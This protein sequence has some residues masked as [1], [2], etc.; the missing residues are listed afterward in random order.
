M[1]FETHTIADVSTQHIT[2]EDGDRIAVNKAPCQIAA[3]DHGGLFYIPGGDLT[4]KDIRLA[5]DE[6]SDA[7]VSLMVELWKQEIV[8]V[9]FDADAS[10]VE[11]A[12]VFDW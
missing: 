2:L 11:G 12:P 5:F 8:Y 10:E 1:K 9:R 6:M 7:F 3:Y 4:E